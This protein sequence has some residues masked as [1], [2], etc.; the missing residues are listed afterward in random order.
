MSSRGERGG[1]GE[2]TFLSPTR[3]VQM[4]RRRVRN[5][6]VGRELAPPV[7]EAPE[8]AQ[9]LE[10]LGPADGG[11]VASEMPRQLHAGGADRSRGAVDEDLPSLAE[12]HL[13]QA[14]TRVEEADGDRGRFL[15]TLPGRHRDEEAA[16]GHA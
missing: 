2:I 11:D 14:E 10:I 3:D 1:G 16:L 4:A 8:R 7:S 5:P 9:E 15:E 6:S 12:V 13:P